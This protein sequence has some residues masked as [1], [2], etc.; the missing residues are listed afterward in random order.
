M[1]D[2]SKEAYPLAS[3]DGDA[4]QRGMTLR[5]YYAGE[6]MKG[7]LSNTDCT[8]MPYGQVANEAIKQADALLEALAK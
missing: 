4:L 5:E 3:L 7:L 8:V 2:I 6:A 1:K